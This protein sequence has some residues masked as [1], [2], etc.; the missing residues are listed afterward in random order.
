MYAKKYCCTLFDSNYMP[1]GLALYE[2]MRRHFP[3]F[4]LWILALDDEC[5]DKL[6]S[7]NLENVTV[8]RL[9][10]VEEADVLEAKG[11]R[12]WQE[13]C[14]TLGSVLTWYVLRENPELDHISYL[15]SDICF[16]SSPEPIYEEIGDKSIMIVPH[17]FPPRLE[18]LAENGIY[19]V[20]MVFFRR[21]EQGQACLEEW[22]DNCVEWCYYKIE[23]D[24]LGDQ[25]YL[26]KWPGKYSNTHILRHLG[27]G[28]ALWNIEQY[29]VRPENGNLILDGQPLIFYHY[30]KFKYF[31]G[32]FYISGLKDYGF[33]DKFL[34]FYR[35]YVKSLNKLTSK[36]SVGARKLDTREFAKHVRY[37]LRSETTL[38]RMK[39]KIMDFAL[40]VRDALRR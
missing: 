32:G 20:E 19:N 34:P 10:E 14:W 39:I 33:S 5:Y 31:D 18:H 1:L 12:T 25:K 24:R 27:A 2:S 36:Y 15:D 40:R 21:D 17:R 9:S 28:V 6:S 26:D 11:N 22:R 3:D 35:P 23:K 8:M 7:S 38:G 30:H 37:E 4:H 16:F 29:D 13:Y